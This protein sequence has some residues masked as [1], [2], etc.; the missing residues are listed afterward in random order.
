MG[1]S[2]NTASQPQNP[3][4]TYFLTLQRSPSGM[5]EV[6]VS[7]QR[8][9]TIEALPNDKDRKE[10]VSGLRALVNF[11]RS[12]VQKNQPG[13]ATPAPVSTQEAR[14]APTQSPPPSIPKIPNFTRKS[15]PSSTAT[16]KP[17]TFAKPGPTLRRQSK[18]P[19][20]MPVI[21]FA[22][23]I[24]E[25]IAQMQPHDPNLAGRS[26]RL[27]NSHSGGVDFAIDGL[28]YTSVD[29]I[30]DAEVQALIRAATKEWEKR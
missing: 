23:E 24:G 4:E 9:Q 17:R 13:A 6:R 29:E 11:S 15:N 27:T 21:N 16:T 30:P 14:F 10:V 26:I 20:L 7:G 5:W 28:V 25:I 3:G 18:A 19:E 12:Y 8:Y 1:A 2:K 22:D